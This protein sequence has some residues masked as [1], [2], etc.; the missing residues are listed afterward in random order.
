MQNLIQEPFG[1]VIFCGD[2]R[3]LTTQ[4]CRSE[5]ARELFTDARK[6]SRASSLL[7]GCVLLMQNLIQEP[8]GPVIFCGDGRCLTTQN[9]RSELARE[10]F[11]DA[12]KSSRAS[13]LL[14]GCVLLMQNLIQEPFGPVIFC[15]DG[16]CLTPQNCRSE[17]AREQSRF[18]RMCAVN[19][20]FDSGTVWSGHFA[21]CRR[22]RS[23]RPARRFHPCP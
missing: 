22:S 1:P 18:Y 10:L 2:G 11:T 23:G 4:N 5:L 15:G 13:S 8:F 12:R 3:C 17:L 9:C 16:R 6:S 7:Q 20:E 21:G 19:A 14:Q